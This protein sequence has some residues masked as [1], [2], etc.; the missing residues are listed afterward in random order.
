MSIICLGFCTLCPRLVVLSGVV[1]G[2][3]SL[4][5]VNASQRADFES[6]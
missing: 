5:A 2:K 3:C 1:M 6:L 4:V